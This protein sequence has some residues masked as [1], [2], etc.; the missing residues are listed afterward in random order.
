[1]RSRSSRPSAHTRS[2]VLTATFEHDEIALNFPAIAVE[3]GQAPQALRQALGNVEIASISQNQRNFLVELASAAQLRS[4]RPNFNLLR[5]LPGEGVI[6]TSSSD[7]AEFDFMSRYF[8]PNLGIL[9]DPVTGMAHCYLA[10]YW[11]QKL[12]QLEL[13]AYQASSRSGRMR[14]RCDGDRVS[15]VG[16]AVTVM[17]GEYLHPVEFA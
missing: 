9:E 13:R 6:V 14:V 12:G 5:Q 15:L 4:L 7:T 10:P 3:P 17:R 1:W 8:A 11:C 2:G 16:I